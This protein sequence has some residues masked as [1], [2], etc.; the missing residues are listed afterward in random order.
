V[1]DLRAY[2][3]TVLESLLADYLVVDPS[4]PNYGAVLQGCFNRPGE[5]AVENELIWTNYYTARTLETYHER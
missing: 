3:E 2:G 1:T 5:Y 4:A